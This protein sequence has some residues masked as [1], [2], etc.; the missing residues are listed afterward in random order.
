MVSD[1]SPPRRRPTPAGQVLVVMVVAFALGSLLNAAALERSARNLAPGP[2]RSIA[3]ALT[4]PLGAIS[5][6]LLLDRPRALIE[7]GLGRQPAP[8]PES[9]A[10][11]PFPLPTTSVPLDT[12]RPDPAG[13]LRPITATDPLRVWVIGDSLV[14]AVGGALIRRAS[15]TPLV[16]ADMTFKYVSGLTRPDFFD[17]PEHVRQQIPLRRPEAVFVMFGGNDGQDVDVGG[18]I[19]EKWTEEWFDWYR[20]KVQEAMRVLAGVDGRVYWIGLPVMKSDVFSEHV[21]LLNDVYR[22]EAERHPTITFV[23]TWDLFVDDSGDYAAYLPDA[24]GTVRLVRA[25]D[26]SHLTP[27]GGDRMTTLLYEHLA[28]DWEL[29]AS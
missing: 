15:T 23:D 21:A 1:S 19:L 3:V 28:R 25:P 6:T 20:T 18:R 12:S 27:A 26:G 10:A 2:A 8:P 17:W 9:D 4:T 5:R 22:T 7:A 11:R 24:D 14:E 13:D 29:P 16:E